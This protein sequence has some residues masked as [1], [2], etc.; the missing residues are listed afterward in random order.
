M[1]K[2]KQQTF[3]VLALTLFPIGEFVQGCV[4]PRKFKVIVIPLQNSAQMLVE[5]PE[6]KS[7]S[8]FPSHIIQG[9][10]SSPRKSNVLVFLPFS[11]F[12]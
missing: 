7:I 10:Q 4:V 11:L 12:L 9:D 5:L 3:S 1:H 6:G 2:E 8:Q